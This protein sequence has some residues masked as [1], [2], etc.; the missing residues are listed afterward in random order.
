MANSNE[1]NGRVN[2]SVAKAGLVLQPGQSVERQE[3][4]VG[5]HGSAGLLA[6]SLGR[7]WSSLA[8]ELRS[9]SGVIDWQ[10]P[11][12]DTEVCVDV[13]GGASVVTRQRNGITDRTVSERGTIWL[14]PPKGPEGVIEMSD[15]LPAVLHIYLPP[16]QFSPKSLGEGSDPSAIASLRYESSF[17]DPLV[18]EMAYAIASELQC[19][20][21]V[22]SML[23]ETLASSLAARLVQNHVGALARDV[24]APATQA[25]LDRR[26]LTRVLDYIAANLEGDLALD[27]LASIACLSRFHFSRSFKAAVGRSPHH[28]VSAKR[29]EF[30]KQLLVRGEQ[31]LAQIAL[32]LKFSCQANFTR[33]FREATGQTPAQYRRSVGLIAAGPAARNDNG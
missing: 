16:S 14:S 26:R 31:P 29:L 6:S 30:A 27:R 32:T 21:S 4:S 28:Y 13:H 7:G 24:S 2:S 8:A 10:N 33:A 15:P 12:P 1:S 11:R 17:Q 25:G 22:G 3:R 19:E 23:I 20:T 5:K 18:A 9:H